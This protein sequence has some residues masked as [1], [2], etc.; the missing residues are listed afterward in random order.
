MAED[1][2]INCGQRTIQKMGRIAIGDIL[3]SNELEVGETVEVF[4]KKISKEPCAAEIAR[5]RKEIS[6]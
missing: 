6:K 2:L 4:L 1:K 3:K 5:T